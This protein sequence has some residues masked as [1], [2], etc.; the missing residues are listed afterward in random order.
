VTFWPDY[1][2]D[3]VPSWQISFLASAQEL[4]KLWHLVNV[5]RIFDHAWKPDSNP[6][7]GGESI[8]LKVVANGRKADIP[9]TLPQHETARLTPLYAAIRSLVPEAVWYQIDHHLQSYRNTHY[10]DAD[11]HLG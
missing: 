9:A 4:T 6:P 1:S 5:C 3:R 2:S 10:R 7:I 11:D 8:R